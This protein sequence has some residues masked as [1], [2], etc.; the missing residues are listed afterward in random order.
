M[1]FS[2]PYVVYYFVNFVLNISNAFITRNYI[3]YVDLTSFFFST[4]SFYIYFSL[5][6]IDLNYKLKSKLFNLSIYNFFFF[7]VIILLE[8]KK[9][10]LGDL[11]TLSKLM[12]ILKLPL[13]F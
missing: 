1:S 7:F 13:H 11:I 8:Q 3:P 12:I 2:K 6:I 5:F 4:I 9:I 10:I